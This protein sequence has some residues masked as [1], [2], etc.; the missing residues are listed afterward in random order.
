MASRP[1]RRGQVEAMI[2]ALKHL[3]TVLEEAKVCEDELV[4]EHL[5]L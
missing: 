1:R 5:V 3:P 4:A 2:A